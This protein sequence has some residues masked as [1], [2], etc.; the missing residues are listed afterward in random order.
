MTNVFVLSKLH[1]I[2][3]ITLSAL[4]LISKDG[5]THLGYTCIHLSICIDESYLT[6]P[7]ILPEGKGPYIFLNIMYCKI[8]HIHVNNNSE[9]F[10]PHSLQ[11]N[12]SSTAANCLLLYFYGQLRLMIP[13]QHL[14]VCLLISI[15]TLM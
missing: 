5:A 9:N 11:K 2:S 8:E 1:I 10:T 15:G 12:S 4:N 6:C 3:K 14:H 7:L 13:P